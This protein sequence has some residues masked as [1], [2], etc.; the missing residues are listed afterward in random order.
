MYIKK[1]KNA[2]STQFVYVDHSMVVKVF[3][4]MQN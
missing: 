2:F 4:F 3:F 1:N